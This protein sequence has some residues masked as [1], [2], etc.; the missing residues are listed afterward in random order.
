[1][2]DLADRNLLGHPVDDF[3]RALEAFAVVRVD[4]DGS[5]VLDVDLGAGLGN[6]AFDRL[7]AWS[8]DETDLVWID[9]D[10][11]DTRGVLAK[12]S[13]WASKNAVHDI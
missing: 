2:V 1:M 4:V 11:F 9:S 12:L 10:G 5:V 8:N 3:F 6:D 13:T 7:A